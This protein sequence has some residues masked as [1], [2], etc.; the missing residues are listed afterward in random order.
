[1]QSFPTAS[2]DRIL[3]PATLNILDPKVF[4]NENLI[5]EDTE[6]HFRSQIQRRLRLL[7]RLS[8]GA[9]AVSVY[10]LIASSISLGQFSSTFNIVSFLMSLISLLLSVSITAWSSKALKAEESDSLNSSEFLNGDLENFHQVLYVSLMFRAVA[11]LPM[12]ANMLMQRDYTAQY[13]T[14]RNSSHEVLHYLDSGNFMNNL[15]TPLPVLELL[16][17]LVFIQATRTVFS[18]INKPN[19]AITRMVFIANLAFLASSFSLIFASQDALAHQAHFNLLDQ[20]PDWILEVSITIGIIASALTGFVWLINHTKWRVP[21]LMIS[22]LLVF[23]TVGFAYSSYNSF[24]YNQSVFRFYEDTSDLPTWRERMASVDRQ[25]IEDFGCPSKYFCH[26]SLLDKIITTLEGDSTR[27]LNTDCAGLLGQMQSSPFLNVCNWNLIS[28]SSGFIILMG[29]IFS[30]HITWRDQR[31]R[32][33]KDQ[34]WLG[35]L[36]LIFLAFFATALVQ[37]RIFNSGAELEKI[38][39]E[40]K[41]MAKAEE[42]GLRGTIAQIKESITGDN[43]ASS[44]EEQGK[45]VTIIE[46]LGDETHVIPGVNSTS[47][48]DSLMFAADTTSPYHDAFKAFYNKKYRFL[49][50]K[51]DPFKPEK[52]RILAGPWKMT[53]E[54]FSNSVEKRREQ[55]GFVYIDKGGKDKI[56]MI[57]FTPK[58]S[59]PAHVLQGLQLPIDTNELKAENLKDINSIVISDV[60]DIT[61]ENVVLNSR[62]PG[63][64]VD[65]PVETE[66][67]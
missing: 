52:V 15:A 18:Y 46:E 48:A 16:L 28:L 6:F 21:H 19:Q 8:Y 40:V 53:F 42:S 38:I 54:N 13:I 49:T 45:I 61:L 51:H 7:N 1:M 31:E 66:T 62:P 47:I 58:D 67:S 43:T 41:D 63:P 56:Y 24:K 20:F 35:F 57:V 12:I 23:L 36:I 30:W 64:V 59:D 65:I 14:A 55:V 10:E 11:S 22:G 5:K 39:E 33:N 4:G 3:Q 17:C 29:L 9:V 25:E 32:D 27:C 26:E 44:N 60:N 2:T 37:N 50:I 34:K